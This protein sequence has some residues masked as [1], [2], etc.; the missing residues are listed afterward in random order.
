MSLLRLFGCC[1]GRPELWELDDESVITDAGA[2][3]SARAETHPTDFGPA[4]G[5][6]TFREGLQW[7]IPQATCRVSLTPLADGLRYETQTYATVLDVAQGSEQR[8]EAPFNVP[9]ARLGLE[10]RVDQITG[11]CQLGEAD[12][13]SVPR[14]SKTGIAQ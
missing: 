12:L 6:G 14:R 4:S 2:P 5:Y 9:G 1:A 10:I 11:A 13:T 3:L 8:I 7:V